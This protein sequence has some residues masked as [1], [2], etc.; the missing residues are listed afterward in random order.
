VG[1]ASEIA[2]VVSSAAGLDARGRRV[3]YVRSFVVGVAYEQRAVAD[4]HR[5]E[6]MQLLVPGQLGAALAHLL[7][8]Y[9]IAVEVVA[10]A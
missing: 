4:Q 7:P 10:A 2:R 6:G 1:E 3:M 9:V 8:I 5:L